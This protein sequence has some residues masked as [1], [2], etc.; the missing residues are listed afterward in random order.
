MTKKNAKKKAARARMEAFGGKYEAQLRHL[1]GGGEARPILMSGKNIR[2]QGPWSNEPDHAEWTTR[3][4]LPALAIR[5]GY[6]VWC[7]YVG[8]PRGHRCYGRSHGDIEALGVMVHLGITYAKAPTE[9]IGTTSADATQPDDLWWVGFFCGHAGDLL[10]GMLDALSTLPS[11]SFDDL[12]YRDLGYVQERSE[13]LATQLAVLDWAERVTAPE[14]IKTTMPELVAV[15][16][17][18]NQAI[19]EAG[20]VERAEYLRPIDEAFAKFAETVRAIAHD[21]RKDKS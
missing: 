19:A 15:L 12:V 16:Q 20:S 18:A 9:L 21:F 7:G 8:V 1:G 17:W 2:T 5:G 13:E 4:G 11:P 10:P 3:A 14:K 6:G